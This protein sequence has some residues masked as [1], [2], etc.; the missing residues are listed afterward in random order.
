MRT[1]R[2]RQAVVLDAGAHQQLDEAASRHLLR[3]LRLKAGDHLTLFDG[4]GR[5]HQATLLA[6]RGRHAEVEIGAPLE[7]N[8][9]SPL[10]IILVQGISRGERMDYTL[11]KAVELGVKCI[12]PLFTA[13]CNVKLTGE[14]LEKRLAHWQGVIIHACE[15]CGRSRLPTLEPAQALEQWQAPEAALKLVLDAAATG[16]LGSL[17][18]PQGM[19]I[20]AIGPEGGLT[21]QE[22]RRLQHQGFQ[23]LRLGPRILRTE[24]AGMAALAA[25][26][27]LWGDFA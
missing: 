4:R 19:V 9:E 1:P 15:Q 26:Q 11:Q 24:T 8:V 3:V 7:R 22:L 23:A 5:E 17:A 25:L 6:G 16:G 18:A 12:A 2:I 21:A 13:R 27:T 20:L 14:R 10:D